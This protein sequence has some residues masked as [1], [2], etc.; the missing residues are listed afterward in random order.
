MT[1]VTFNAIRLLCE[2]VY[3]LV[4]GFVDFACISIVFE[5]YH[6]MVFFPTFITNGPANVM[7]FHGICYCTLMGT[8]KAP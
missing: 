5:G 4:T 3:V 8:N 7:T 2:F 1:F 6:G